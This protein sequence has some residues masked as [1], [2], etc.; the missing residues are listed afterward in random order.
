MEIIGQNAFY[1]CSKLTALDLSSTNV[2]IIGQSAF[3]NCFKDSVPTTFNLGNVTQIGPFAFQ[4]S[5]KLTNVTIPNTVIA[6]GYKAFTGV[7]SLSI[8][9]DPEGKTGSWYAFNYTSGVNQIRNELWNAIFSSPRENFT[10]EEIASYEEPMTYQGTTYFVPF[11]VPEGSSI[12]AE[13]KNVMT[14]FGDEQPRL[15]RQYK[16]SN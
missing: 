13:I 10:D 6:L 1:N 9:S 16:D 3:Y 5:S 2:K 14:G 8:A 15:I 7:T 11:T 4:N 12:Q